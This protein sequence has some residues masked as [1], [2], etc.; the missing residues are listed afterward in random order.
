[1]FLKSLRKA[2]TWK[3]N[4]YSWIILFLFK[5][6]IHDSNSYRV[7]CLL[8]FSN[9]AIWRGSVLIRTLFWCIILRIFLLYIDF[10]RIR[11]IIAYKVFG[12]FVSLL[13]YPQ[14]LTYILQACY[15][16]ILLNVFSNITLETITL[17]Q[18]TNSSV[19]ILNLDFSYRYSILDPKI[20]GN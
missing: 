20:A 16:L 8:L 13:L 7:V 6:Q 2:G 3:L 10:R 18:R 19:K 15:Q 12:D 5:I 17:K 14:H 11:F 9:R 1:M 4:L